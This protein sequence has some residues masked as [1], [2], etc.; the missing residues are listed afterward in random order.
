[1]VLLVRAQ[2]PACVLGQAALV[3]Y[4]WGEEQGVQGRAAKALAGVRAGGDG[5]ERRAAGLRLQA[6]YRCCP[7]LGAHAAPQ[8]DR[9]IPGLVQQHGELFQAAGAVG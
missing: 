4:G 6:G 9:V 5:H 2:D 1:V 8:D 7:A 3:G